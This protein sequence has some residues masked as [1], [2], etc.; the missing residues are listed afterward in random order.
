[1]V[2]FVKKKYQQLQLINV[3]KA[4]YKYFKSDIIYVQDSRVRELLKYIPATQNKKK[5][6]KKTKHTNK[7]KQQKNPTQVIT[8]QTH[9]R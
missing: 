5:P 8:N 3:Y 2:N 9:H 6:T 7:K 4:Q 1:M